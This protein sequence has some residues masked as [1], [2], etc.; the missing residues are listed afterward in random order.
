MGSTD[1]HLIQRRVRRT[2]ELAR[3]RRALMGILPVVLV[4]A[5][6]AFVATR[7]TAPLAFGLVTA[8]AGAMM[9]W[10]GK[11]PQKAFLPGVIAGLV[12][13]G[14][15]LGAGALHTCG[16]GSCSYVCVPA[17]VLGGVV[18]GFAVAGVSLQRRAG[19][20][21]WVS[22]SGLALLTGAMGCGCMG[23]AGVI[24]MGLGFGAGIVP[25]LLRRV[26]GKDTR[27]PG[28]LR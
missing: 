11:D 7:P 15:A 22:A 24:G 12:P 19:V 1:L 10:H 21:F 14:L 8:F 17:C 27:Q 9:L 2:Y 28:D 4:T 5:V 23:S 3:L 13:L 20:W 26:F 16:A 6:A 18:A 25:G